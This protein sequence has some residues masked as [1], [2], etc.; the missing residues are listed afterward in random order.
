MF[1]VIISFSTAFILSF[2]L[3]RGKVKP[4][5]VALIVVASGALIGWQIMHLFDPGRTSIG[6]LLSTNPTLSVIW[7]QTQDITAVVRVAKYAVF[8]LV[9]FNVVASATGFLIANLL[10]KKR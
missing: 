6:I 2:L 5:V 7:Q 10:A 3:I 4:L 9:G 1:D 8:Y